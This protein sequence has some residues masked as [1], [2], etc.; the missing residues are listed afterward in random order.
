MDAVGNQV[1]TSS[2][3]QSQLISSLRQEIVELQKQLEGRSSI[4]SCTPR[5]GM[6]FRN[7]EVRCIII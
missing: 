1:D 7:T 2:D 6:R 5:K 3:L 4:P